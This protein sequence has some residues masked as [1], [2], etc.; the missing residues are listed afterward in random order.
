MASAFL[1]VE[2]FRRRARRRLPRVAFDFVD[3]AAESEG[4]MRANLSAFTE[5]H[6]RPRNG[7]RVG[8]PD[9]R[10]TV[11]GQELS[12]P[13]ALAPCGMARVVH[14]AGDLAAVRAAGRAGTAFTLSTMSGHALEEIAAASA[15]PLWY[16]VYDVG[17]RPRVERALARAA[18]A[19]Y[20]A[21]MVT[22]DTQV[23]AGRLR[24]SRNGT[25]VLLGPRPLPKARYLPQMLANPGWL[26]RRF[27]DGLVP[28]VPN[29]LQEDGTPEYLWK[30]VR[31]CSLS[32]EDFTWLRE[33]W[34]GPVMV[35]GV[36]G[37]EDTRRAVD[38]GVDA[39]IVSNHGGR[40]LDGV[41]ATLEVLPEVIG[42]A[43]G[44]CEVLL[45]GG[46]R[47]GNDV[48]KALALGARAVLIGRPWMY[49]LGG[50]GEAGIDRLLAIL[51]ADLTRDLQ[52]M[53]CA[54]LSELGAESVTA[55]VSWF[56]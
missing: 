53:G 40:Q 33:A 49:A 51:R 14:P 42:A 2:D 30:N 29:V 36:L 5:V 13:V 31:P 26:A 24:D 27:R 32:W 38:L 28:R 16:Q 23:S 3:G 50:A 17:G 55:P 45:D 12:M 44:R 4:T 35:K 10:T 52:L 47:R 41:H 15:G 6:L 43:A 25:A 37:A 21:I 39:V 11:L 9:L 22:L 1:T 7:T 56:G 34:K 19:G 20:R 46:I 54:K 8:L 48:V 18:E